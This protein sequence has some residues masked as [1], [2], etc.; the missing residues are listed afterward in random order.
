MPPTC[1]AALP[2]AAPQPACSP[3]SCGTDAPICDGETG[4]C[5][6]CIADAECGGNG[7][8][9]EYNGL[10]VGENAVIY[11]SP[12]GFDN[13]KCNHGQPCRTFAA[14]FAVL[15]P[16]RRTIRVAPG[17]YLASGSSIVTVND[18]NGRIEISGEDADPSDTTFQSVSNGT[19]N[20]STVV[21]NSKTDVVI[22]G[23]TVKECG[24]D[25]V[26]ANASLL[27]S[28]AAIVACNGRGLETSSG[29]TVHV[30]DSAITDNGDFGVIA[31]DGTLE[32][33]RSTIARNIDGG[34]VTNRIA[35]TV[36]GSFIV[37]N[38]TV[39]KSLTGGLRLSNTDGLPQRISFLTV[40]F[41]Q[42]QL[43]GIAGLQA[44]KPVVVENS[45]FVDNGLV[46]SFQICIGCSARYTMFS[47][48]SLPIGDGNID[49]P[50]DFVDPAA[51]DFHL[52]SSSKAR[53]AADPTATG[54][55]D[56]DGDARPIGGRCDIGADEIR[57]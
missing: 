15:E 13:G 21:T 12:N 48:F 41:N 52:K 29:A 54:L 20:P 16:G 9:T 55:V 32:V 31:Q 19:S 25:G 37:R 26:H 45:I 47:G 3:G 35:L 5:R 30:W 17:A 27:L 38:G 57:L 33:L 18:T 49:D 8:C 50:A 51:D 28:H 40:A 44:D 14:A 39:D 53:D 56:A 4:A 10:C 24:N 36:E 11:I 2:D 22:E 23:V 46:D 1:V 43:S 34:I 42:A 7:A 6:G